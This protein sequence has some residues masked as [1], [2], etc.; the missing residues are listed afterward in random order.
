VDRPTP[1][2]WPLP[3]V[4]LGVSV[5]NQQWADI[6]IPAL[7]ETPAAVRW[8][9]C[10]P[11]LGPLDLRRVPGIDGQYGHAGRHNGAGTPE[12]P[13]A[14][15]HHHDDRCRFPIDWVVAGGESGL[16]ARPMHPDWARG[17]RDACTAASVPYF[18]KQWGEWRNGSADR[19]TE[20]G[21]DHAVMRDGRHVLWSD[22]AD[23]D[24]V[25]GDPLQR[26]GACVMA[27]VGK[28]A[29]GR[30]LDGRTWDEY[31]G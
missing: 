4:W 14:S 5:E 20:R 21:P 17:L 2:Q 13:R 9:S 1:L 10:E 24:L 12:C 8:L 25:K 23:S 16:G 15:H 18:F 31:P 7:L 26:H 19:R 29:A 3:N 11:L 6:R 22:Y 27:R 30:E 28:K